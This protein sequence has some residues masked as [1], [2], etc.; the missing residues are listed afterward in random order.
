MFRHFRRVGIWGMENAF[1][2][3]LVVALLAV[4]PVLLRPGPARADEAVNDL[5]QVAL[6]DI[7]L[8]ERLLALEALK[9]KG[10][11]AAV[12]ALAD[13]AASGDLRIAVAACAQLG[14]VKSSGSKG[15]L[16]TLLEKS[17]LGVHVRTAAASAIAEHWKDSG[18]MDY[19]E[20]KCESND[21]LKAHYAELKKRVYKDE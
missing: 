8:G 12:E 3:L 7:A 2:L 20:G 15:E 4:G 14:R 17:S 6:S 9:E 16:K 18:D 13:I 11:E 19:L 1:G 5:K 21:A 10:S